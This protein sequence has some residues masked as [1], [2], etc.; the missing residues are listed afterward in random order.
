MNQP[1]NKKQ[2]AFTLAEL[3]LV[4]SIMAILMGAI[5][6]SLNHALSGSVLKTASQTIA[7]V[8]RYARSIAIERSRISKLIFDRESGNIVFMVEGDPMT[9]PGVFAEELIP[10]RFQKDVAGKVQVAQIMKM[11][12]EG[13]QE[14]DEISFNPNGS[15]SDTFLYLTDEQ[16]RVYTIGVVGLTGQVLV[17]N[18]R[19]ESFYEE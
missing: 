5:V 18:R 9:S 14:E 17:W 4:I 16:E 10:V 7:N 13:S 12:L 3:M 1:A 2:N 11:N 15:T 8:M 19:V 6:P